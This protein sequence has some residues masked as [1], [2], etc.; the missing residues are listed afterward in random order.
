MCLRLL[1]ISSGFSSVLIHVG[2]LLVKAVHDPQLVH[3]GQVGQ[4]RDEERGDGKVSHEGGDKSHHD[5]DD[6]R[7]EKEFHLFG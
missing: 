3:D 6:Q 2:N 4:Q 1:I 7:D 5:D